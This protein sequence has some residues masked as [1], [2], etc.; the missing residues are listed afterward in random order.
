MQSRCNSNANLMQFRGHSL[1]DGINVGEKTESETGSLLFQGWVG[2]W[3]DGVEEKGIKPS[4]LSTRL[5]MK[6]KL[7]LGLAI[8]KS[9]MDHTQPKKTI[10]DVAQPC[11]TEPKRIIQ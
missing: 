2:G 7:K 10:Q 6:L 4:Q 5:K 11:S 3:V 1:V 8:L 9:L